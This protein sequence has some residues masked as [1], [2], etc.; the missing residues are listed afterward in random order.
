[1]LFLDMLPLVLDKQ[2]QRATVYRENIVVGSSVYLYLD[3]R[4]YVAT[5]MSGFDIEKRVGSVCY[6]AKS[7]H[8]IVECVNIDSPLEC[9]HSEGAQCFYFIGCISF[10]IN[11]DKERYRQGSSLAHR[12]T[13]ASGFVADKVSGINIG[14]RVVSVCYQDESGRSREERVSIDSPRV[15]AHGTHTAKLRCAVI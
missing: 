15:W 10:L 3:N 5:K 4:G 13:C 12:S 6:V 11:N 8:S 7:G 14:K 2:C 9:G 1:M